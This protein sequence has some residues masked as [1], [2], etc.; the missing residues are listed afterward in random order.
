MNEGEIVNLS[1]DRILWVIPNKGG[2]A[3]F[4][5]VLPPWVCSL[6][7]TIKWSANEGS[8]LISL[9]GSHAVS[10]RFVKLL[11][12]CQCSQ[13][14]PPIRSSH[15]VDQLGT[16][17]LP[18][19]QGTIT[20]TPEGRRQKYPSTD[21]RSDM[22]YI[23]SQDHLPRGSIPYLARLQRTCRMYKGPKPASICLSCLFVQ[24]P[25]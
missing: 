24:G 4:P 9:Q 16:V 2:E 14:V 22:I 20:L 21:K 12:E 17:K 13:R 23:K 11:I 15:C 18:S 5:F 25:G 19:S 3:A 10:T 6:C 7:A 8:H 1:Q